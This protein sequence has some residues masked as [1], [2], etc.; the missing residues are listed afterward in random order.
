MWNI[1]KDLL[2][3]CRS[4]A[5]YL[6]VQSAGDILAGMAAGPE[7]GRPASYS[8][9]SVVAPCLLPEQEQVNSIRVR[10]PRYYPRAFIDER[11]ADLYS[12]R[13]LW[14]Q[15]KGGALPYTVDSSGIRSL[16]ASMLDSPADAMSEAR[17]RT[18]WAAYSMIEQGGMRAQT[19]LLWR[20]SVGLARAWCRSSLAIASEKLYDDCMDAASGSGLF[21]AGSWALLVQSTSL[22]S[23]LC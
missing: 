7:N 22:E 16:L 15:L 2:L 18:D 13:T 12:S 19:P 4:S 5:I 21:G 3:Y 6:P 20:R 17:I 9:V 14:V 1:K 11:L 23:L 10:G 8:S